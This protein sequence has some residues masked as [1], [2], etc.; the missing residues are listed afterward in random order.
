MGWYGYWNLR[1]TVVA[2]WPADDDAEGAAGDSVTQ[3][4]G[5]QRIILHL[6]AASS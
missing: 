1:V 3:Q 5:R 4:Q 6:S 2:G